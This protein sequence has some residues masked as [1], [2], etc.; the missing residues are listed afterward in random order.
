[1]KF[2]TITSLFL[3]NVGLSL[4]APADAPAKEPSKVLLKATAIE[5]TKGDNGITTPLPIQP[6]MVDNCDRFH[7]VE[8]NTGC[9]GIASDYGLNVE[10]FMAWHPNVG[11][12]CEYLWA[13][14]YACI[15]TIGYTPPTTVKCYGNTEIFPWGAD[16]AAGLAAAKEWCYNGGGGGVYEIYEEKKTCINA[17]SGRGKFV[18]KTK[19]SH[20]ARAGLTGGR[21]QNLLGLGIN[22]CSFGAIGNDGFWMTSFAKGKCDE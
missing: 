2:S 6:G 19:T 18:F 4:A 8:K 14:A 13:E 3:A 5:T 7:F 21:C 11:K 15:H 10:Q 16:K 17:P 9:L 20:G 22:G 12:N 1:M